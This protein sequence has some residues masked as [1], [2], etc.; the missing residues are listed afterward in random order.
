MKNGQNNDASH[1]HT[2]QIQKLLVPPIVEN[3]E[4]KGSLKTDDQTQKLCSVID[5]SIKFKIHQP[6]E[7]NKESPGYLKIKQTCGGH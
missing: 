5:S 1:L 4:L 6:G 3:T 2:A 7:P